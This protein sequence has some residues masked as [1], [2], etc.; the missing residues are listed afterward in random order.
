MAGQEVGDDRAPL[1]GRRTAL[2]GA[3]EVEDVLLLRLSQV[4]ESVDHAIGLRRRESPVSGA[5][6]GLDRLQ[7]VGRR[8]VVEEED[9]LPEP[10][11]CSR[12]SEKRF[13]CLSFSAA[14]GWFPVRRVGVWY[15]AQP[16]SSHTCFPRRIES[17]EAPGN[18]STGVGG[19]CVSMKNAKRLTSGTSMPVSVTVRAS[20]GTG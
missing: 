14:I 6:V 17:A 15:S 7:Q 16:I 18:S 4:V 3:Q 12:R 20:F 10:M 13:A 5:P 19:A 9:P 1:G 8:P 2:Q 11:L